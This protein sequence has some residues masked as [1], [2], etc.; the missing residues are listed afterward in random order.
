MNVKNITLIISVT[1]L[2]T[3]TKTNP[4]LVTITGEITNPIGESVI[5]SNQDTSYSTTVNKNGSFIISFNLDSATNLNFEHGVERTAMYVKPGDKIKLSID[6][7]KF[8]ET[9]KYEGSMHSSYL[10]EKYLL[11]EDGNFYG[12]VYYMSSAEEYKEILDRYRIAVINQVSKITDSTFVNNQ[13]IN[14]DK[15]V[16]SA[17]EK[18]KEL[19]DKNSEI[20]RAYM[21]KSRELARGFNFYTAMDSL[22]STDFNEMLTVYLE[23]N[24]QRPTLYDFLA[25][26]ALDFFQNPE[27]NLT[28]PADQFTLNGEEYFGNA[29]QFTEIP[30]ETKDSLS[31]K[32]YEIV[33]FFFIKCIILHETFIIFFLISIFAIY[34]HILD[35]L[36]KVQ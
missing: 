14:M 21:W 12:K 36:V 35:I 26:R 30:T 16:N 24:E 10:A 19:V 28:R 8:D 29:L 25:H 32:L 15:W 11:E 9:I 2:I 34:I 20:I 13:I 27:R 18:Q 5:F 3:C 4:N 33:C 31:N 23:D 1:L 17:V 22:N 6:T 7:E